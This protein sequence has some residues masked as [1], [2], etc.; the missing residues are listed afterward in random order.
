VEDFPQK[1][2]KELRSKYEAEVKRLKEELKELGQKSMG[3]LANSIPWLLQ[4]IEG[5]A[6]GETQG[7]DDAPPA[8]QQ[9]A[10]DASQ[11]QAEHPQQD[12]DLCVPEEAV[13]PDDGRRQSS[14]TRK[15]TKRYKPVDAFTAQRK[16]QH[17][18]RGENLSVV[19]ANASESIDEDKAKRQCV[20]DESSREFWERRQRIELQRKEDHLRSQTSA[21]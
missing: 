19:P 8:E 6:G 3:R 21:Q 11:E 4:E 12:D 1:T 20:S 10:S 7:H 16:R 2:V 14:R 5:L 15:E 9:K 13:Q 18:Q 17:S